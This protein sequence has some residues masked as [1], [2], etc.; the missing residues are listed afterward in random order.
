M[1][2]LCNHIF[3]CYFQIH[4]FDAFFK[5]PQ[6]ATCSRHDAFETKSPGLM[7]RVWDFTVA[8]TSR[9]RDSVVAVA[10][11][12]WKKCHSITVTVTSRICNGVTW[13]ADW[14]WDKL[15]WLAKWIWDGVVWLAEWTWNG[16]TWMANCILG[17]VT[18][19]GKPFT[20]ESNYVTNV[21]AKFYG[22]YVDGE[23]RAD[24]CVV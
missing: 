10:T 11:R 8:T 15:A 22:E 4:K 21:A 19:A 18:W 1:P 14:I 5:Y 9:A 24:F 20:V 12:V 3:S 2:C 17:E 23:W 13:M 6:N 7:I 16:I